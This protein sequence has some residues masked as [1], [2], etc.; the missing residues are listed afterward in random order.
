MGGAHIQ[1][2][3]ANFSL[4]VPGGMRSLRNTKTRAA[5][6]PLVGRVRSVRAPAY[7]SI[8]QCE[9]NDGCD[10]Q[11]IHLQLP[12][13]VNEPPMSGPTAADAPNALCYAV[14]DACSKQL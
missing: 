8:M 3:R 10:S 4:N 1:S 6:M 2:M 7:V 5:D 12:L 11:K 9:E 14:S 13:F